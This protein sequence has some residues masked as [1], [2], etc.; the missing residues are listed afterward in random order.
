MYNFFTGMV[1]VLIGAEKMDRI[2]GISERKSIWIPSTYDKLG[3]S[4]DSSTRKMKTGGFP[5]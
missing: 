5:H 2:L 4:C 1:F 3:M